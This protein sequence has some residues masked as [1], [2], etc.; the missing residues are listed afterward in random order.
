MTAPRVSFVMPA[1]D[2]AATLPKAIASIQA[3]TVQDWELLLVDDGS[4]DDTLAVAR[5]AAARDP[6]IV[7]HT[8]PN[9]GPASARNRAIR[10]ARGTWLMFHD[11]DDWL[12]PNFLDRML[13]VA[14]S[15]PGAT[16]AACTFLGV[17][18]DGRLL[19]VHGVR[20]LGEPFPELAR[21]CPFSPIAVLVRRDAVVALGGF[22]ET[23]ITCEDWDLWLRLARRGA[24]F[25]Q[26]SEALAYY[27][28]R[29]GS[30]TRKTSRLLADSRFVI[31]RGHGRDAREREDLPYAAGADPAGA[32]DAMA[33]SALYIAATGLGLGV[34]PAACFEGLYLSGWSFD[35]KVLAGVT[36]D[37]MAYGLACDRRALAESWPQTRA[38]Y[39]ALCDALREATGLTRQIDAFAAYLDL[40]TRAAAAFAEPQRAGLVQ[41]L[42]LDPGGN[43]QRLDADGRDIVIAAVIAGD[44]AIGACEWI[45]QDDAVDAPAIRAALQETL[46][47]ASPKA[48]L[49]ATP[50]PRR[51]AFWTSVARDAAPVLAARARGDALRGLVRRAAAAALTHSAPPSA[52]LGKGAPAVAA[53]FALVRSGGAAA[54][55]AALTA[56]ETHGVEIAGLADWG[57]AARAGRVYGAC[58]LIGLDAAGL[59]PD[60]PELRLCVEAGAPVTVF[61]DDAELA[62]AGA[63]RAGP[64]V[65]IGW[66]AGATARLSAPE[67]LARARAARAALGDDAWALMLAGDQDSTL[68]AALRQAGFLGAASPI[69][70]RAHVGSTPFE[71]LTTPLDRWTPPDMAARRLGLARSSGLTRR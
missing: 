21:T 33:Q 64:R 67:L 31:A 51:A 69:H 15:E 12:A 34:E 44:T 18:D 59:A 27:R 4:R 13:A 70:G 57:R 24:V 41:T 50:A 5:A 7:V 38:R 2:A 55:R 42:R 54:L 53:P 71:R 40:E 52:V 39:A 56:F 10:E 66:R 45:A 25:A 48:L 29:P 14:A 20:D 60:A 63:W 65:K 19:R 22:D 32:V 36:V 16:L 26:T 23:L 43:R 9:G 30:L 28:S 35:A 17:D 8:K 62:G 1:Y 61:L 6:R 37:A 68:R 49:R 47:V 3:Q 58:A 11:S 46:S